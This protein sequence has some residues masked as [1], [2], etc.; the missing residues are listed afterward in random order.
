MNN[1]FFPKK[2]I[3]WYEQHKRDLPWRNT[4]DAYKIWLSEVILQQTRVSQGLPY[5]QHFISK[6]PNIIKLANA[7]EQEILRSWQGLGYYSRARNLHK[8][9][10]II[11]SEYGGKFPETYESILKLP[12]IGKYTAAAIASFAF[13]EKVAVV[14]GN[15]YRVLSRVY[16]MKDDIATGKGQK[17]F[18]IKAQELISECDPDIY[19]QGI[20]EFGALHCTPKQPG[21]ASCIFH[22]E[23]EA[24]KQGIQDELPVK[25]KKLKIKKRYFSYVCIVHN[26]RLLLKQ[27]KA[28]DVWQG[29][30]DFYLLETAKTAQPDDLFTMDEVVRTLQKENATLVVSPEYIH[31]LSHQKIFAT[32]FTFYSNGSDRLS[33]HL[34][35]ED[36]QFYDL[37][38]IIDLPKPVL[39]SRYLNDT[40]F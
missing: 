28:K 11:C 32:F 23:C 24:R 25:S 37:D 2:I 22:V 13:G 36:Y 1:L 16:G 18:A 12:G 21:C 39:I 29:L 34:D 27:R 8:C 3:S 19:N 5:Y 14:D 9:A 7:K 6:Y 20:M 40:F 33:D 35:L 17:A 15:V 10:K 30:Y 31:V 4:L 38:D 26:N